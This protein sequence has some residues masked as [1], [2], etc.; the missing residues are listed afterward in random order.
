MSLFAFFLLSG[1]L[2]D[3][4]TGTIFWVFVTFVLLVFILQ[5]FAWKPI[6]TALEERQSRIEDS[7]KKAEESNKEAARIMAKFDQIVAE[8]TEKA[9][10]I[11][12]SARDTSE[13]IKADTL[14]KTKEEADKLIENAKAEIERE[15]AAMVTELRQEMVGIILAVSEKVIEANLDTDKNRTLI[16]QSLDHL[17]KN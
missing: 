2:L 13:K 11:V 17:S 6:I 12:R 1:G 8:A 7:F 16:N 5:K 10:I 14:H 15:R 3:P 9:D 4:H